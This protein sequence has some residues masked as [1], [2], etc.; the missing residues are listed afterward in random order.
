MKCIPYLLFFTFWFSLGQ[1][2]RQEIKGLIK[3]YEQEPV[4]GVTI[5]NK[6]TQEGTITNNQGIFTITAGP[7]DRLLLQALQYD[8][9]T[10]VVTAV[11]LE[12]ELLEITLKEGINVLDEVELSD[13]S[14]LVSVVR[15]K[16]YNEVLREVPIDNIKT[17]PSDRKENILS[18]KVRP[19]EDYQLEHTAANQNGLRTSMFDLLGYLRAK[20]GDGKIEPQ[21]IIL[22]KGPKPEDTKRETLLKKYEPQFLIDLLKLE[23]ENLEAFMYYAQ[24]AGL[25]KEMLEPDNE[26]QTLEWLQVQAT[27]FKKRQKSGTDLDKK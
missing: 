11:T 15:K 16:D 23:P 22:G 27:E 25:T 1:V 20:K 26:L 19:P 17:A 9:F 5:F 10:V 14:I 3:N 24:D 18:D 4:G 7:D 6:Q 13:R 21:P 2:P 12:A 8:H